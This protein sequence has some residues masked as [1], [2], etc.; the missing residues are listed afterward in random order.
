M[1]RNPSLSDKGQSMAEFAVG[2]VVLMILAAGIA[3]V[4]RA[5]F[6]YMAIREA[7]QE[8]A[9]YGSTNPTSTIGIQNRV[10]NSSNLLHGLSTD[11]TASTSVQT[12][13]SGDPCT[14]G[15][16]RVQ[17]NYSN[18]PLAMPFLGAVIGS[19]TIGIS[20]SA[21]DTILSPACH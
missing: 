17:V 1:V 7:A 21:T 14:G 5:L 12:T 18:F 2:L 11:L 19:Q 13:I 6:T 9:L 15:A 3:D 10:Y 20:A 4:G 16:I 8:G